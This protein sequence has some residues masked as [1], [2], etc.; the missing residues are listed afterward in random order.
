MIRVN[1]KGYG[2]ITIENLVLDY[3]GTL[4]KD[5]NLLFGVGE[6]IYKLA[7]LVNIYIITADTFG[8][9]E[10]VM[11]DYPVRILLL[12]SSDETNEKLELVKKLGP[13]S[14]MS[15]GNGNN[16]EFM[17]RESI[18]GICIM[19]QEGCSKR[20]FYS[21]DLIINDIR[22]ALGLLIFPDRLKATLRF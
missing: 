1:I 17:L 18:V 13:K 19:G 5:G 14:T 12:R 15:I 8:N 10:N 6:I 4:A 16:D 20:A 3:N 2:D 9:V 11:K 7:K 21:S 22:D